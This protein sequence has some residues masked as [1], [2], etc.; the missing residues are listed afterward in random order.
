M[1]VCVCG[2]NFAR[3]RVKFDFYW[4]KIYMRYWLVPRGNNFHIALFLSFCSTLRILYYSHNQETINN[5]LRVRYY[6]SITAEH[7]TQAV[8]KPVKR[9]RREMIH[10]Y[11]VIYISNERHASNR[12][13]FYYATRYEI[14]LPYR[15][16]FT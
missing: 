9:I 11:I 12:P 16:H 15:S 14:L 7:C 3:V 1:C 10:R 4:N 8:C 6:Y 5:Y 13:S 2:E